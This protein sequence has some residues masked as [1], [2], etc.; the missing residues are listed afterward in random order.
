MKSLAAP[1]FACLATALECRGIKQAVASY[2]DPASNKGGKIAGPIL[3]KILLEEALPDSDDARSM[4]FSP[5]GKPSPLCLPCAR[6]E[7]ISWSTI[8]TSMALFP[9]RQATQPSGSP[10]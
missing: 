7:L 5:D 2:T 1:D 6:R 10:R 9:L 3:V 4:S 8:G